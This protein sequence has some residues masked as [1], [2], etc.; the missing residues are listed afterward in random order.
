MSVLYKPINFKPQEFMPEKVYNELVAAG[1]DPMIVMDPLIVYTI[2]KIRDHFK[3][4]ITI[5]NWLFQKDGFQF[6]GFRP[7]WYT[8]TAAQY[9]QHYFGRALDFDI[10]GMKAEEF[11]SY[12]KLNPKLDAFS[13]ITACEKN[14]TWIHIDCRPTRRNQTGILWING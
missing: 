14:L 6:R 4:S 5:N 9:S 1:A 7:R 10:D 13:Y 12:L 3:K 8:Q 2:D 11:R